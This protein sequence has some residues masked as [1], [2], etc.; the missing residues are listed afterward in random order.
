MVGDD[1][2]ET[3]ETMHMLTTLKT[4]QTEWIKHY[5]AGTLLTEEMPTELVQPISLLLNGLVHICSQIRVRPP[6]LFALGL[7]PGLFWYLL[8]LFRDTLETASQSRP[9]SWNQTAGSPR[10]TSPSKRRQRII[11]SVHKLLLV[12]ID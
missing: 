2:L 12:I 4:S 11:I 6:C 7:L 8:W 5:G 10:W 3:D 9:L 1:K